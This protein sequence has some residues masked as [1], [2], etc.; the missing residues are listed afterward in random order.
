MLAIAALIQS[1]I[2]LT[3]EPERWNHRAQP[4]VSVA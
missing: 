1:A 4:D 2:P 3:A